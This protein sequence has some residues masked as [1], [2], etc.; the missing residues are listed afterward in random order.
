M[1]PPLH[2]HLIDELKTGGAQTHL[3]TMLR[4][5]LSRYPY[6]H[7]AAALFGDGP[8]GGQLRALGGAATTFGRREVYKHN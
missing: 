5:S 4:E 7:R 2:I 6:R 8:I 1:A 3:V